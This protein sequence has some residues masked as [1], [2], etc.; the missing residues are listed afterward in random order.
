[1]GADFSRGCAHLAMHPLISV[2]HPYPSLRGL[3][4]RVTL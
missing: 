4:L 1:L 3:T 2:T